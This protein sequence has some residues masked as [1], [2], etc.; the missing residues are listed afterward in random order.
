MQIQIANQV[1]CA[2]LI[3]S[4]FQLIQKMAE[5]EKMDETQPTTNDNGNG[6]TSKNKPENS[7]SQ[8]YKLGRFS[9]MFFAR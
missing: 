9:R 2:N 3:F 7:T 5:T 8:V 6:I 1:L 4:F